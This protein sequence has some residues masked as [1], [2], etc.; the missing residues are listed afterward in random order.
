MML[1][2]H[3]G[4]PGRSLDFCRRVLQVS[5]FPCLAKA[6]RPGASQLVI[7]K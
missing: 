3:L 6:A 2:E 7:R 5:A 1:S 4:W